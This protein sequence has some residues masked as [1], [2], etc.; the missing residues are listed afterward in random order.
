MAE[1]G[2]IKPMPPIKPISHDVPER[3]RKRRP[4]EEEKSG[5]E[6]RH[7]DPDGRPPLVDEYA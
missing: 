1:I 3:D 6:R 5:D 7:D 2:N 4:P